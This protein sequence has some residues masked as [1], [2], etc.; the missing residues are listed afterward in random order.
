MP[1]IT[2]YQGASAGAGEL[3]AMVAQALGYRCVGRAT[4]AQN[5]KRYGVSQ[6]K[7]GEILDREADWWPTLLKHLRQQ[8]IALRAALC[9]H[10][11]DGRVVYHGRLGHDLL[12]GISHVLRVLIITPNDLPISQ[13]RTRRRLV[14]GWRDPSRYDLVLN[15]SQMQLRS[16]T[17]LIVAS[18]SLDEYQPTRESK[19]IFGDLSLAARV[20]ARLMAA[21]ELEGATVAVKAAHGAVSV[22]GEVEHWGCD[23]VVVRIARKVS[24]VTQVTTDLTVRSLEK[25]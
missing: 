15:M 23:R 11:A 19:Q 12:P 8:G 18:A 25:V 13:E 10:A 3:A 4:L 14:S 21:R 5:A 24:G 1:I 16:A 9:E 20:Q 7:I 2:I 6:A 22:S 17:R